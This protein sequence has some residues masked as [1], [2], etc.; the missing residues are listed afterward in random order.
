MPPLPPDILSYLIILLGDPQHLQIHIHGQHPF[1][2]GLHGLLVL[3]NGS[4][5]WQAHARHAEVLLRGA[6][7]VG[8]EDG[9][10]VLEAARGEGRFEEEGLGV[11]VE[12]ERG[13]GGVV[14]C[15]FFFD[16]SMYM[17]INCKR[18]ALIKEKERT[19]RKSARSRS[20]PPAQSAPGTPPETPDPSRSTA[21]LSRPAYRTPRADRGP[22]TS[23]TPAPGARGSSC[24]RSRGS[25][26]RGR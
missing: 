2:F 10:G 4:H 23:G 26:R 16:V 9:A 12:G 8:E 18:K 5:V 13:G 11:G 1:L 21:R 15:P 3:P 14:S 19:D 20:P 6:R 7:D 17:Y 25:G 22:R 24:G